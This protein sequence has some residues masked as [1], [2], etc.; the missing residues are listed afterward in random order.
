MKKCNS[1]ILVYLIINTGLLLGSCNNNQKASREVVYSGVESVYQIG[2]SRLNGSS[3]FLESI[4]GINVIKLNS[5]VDDA[6]IIG[7][8]HKV[9]VEGNKI[10]LLDKRHTNAI[11]IY[12]TDGN[13]SNILSQS[14]QGEGKYQQISDFQINKNKNELVVLDGNNATLLF[15]SL[16]D[17]AYLRKIKLDF[18]VNSFGILSDSLLVLDRGNYIT[19]DT[20]NVLAIISSINGEMVK[21]LLPRDI[22]YEN[23]TISPLNPFHQSKG[24]LIFHP[25]MSNKTYRIDHDLNISTD[26]FFDF[27]SH[28]VTNSFIQKNSK[29]H[30]M[31]IMNNMQESGY[32]L[33]LNIVEAKD[34][35]SL[36]YY[37]GTDQMVTFIEKETREEQTFLWDNDLKQS[38]EAPIAAYGN[39]FVSIKYND[40]SNP[41][42]ILISLK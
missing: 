3:Q 40:D 42:I 31:K 9:I 20:D 8:I 13:L 16:D 33:F 6:N 41:T 36:S 39:K 21:T 27:G 38:F 1:C 10:Y 15:Y 35:Y 4:S 12:F 18:A 2:E 5:D 14:G 26:C 29:N 32:V 19:D 34:H 30:P 28:W 7:E 22:A 24:D 17:L 25:S 11:H 37:K 23:F